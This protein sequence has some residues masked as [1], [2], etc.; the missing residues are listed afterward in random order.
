[1]VT[2]VTRN[3]DQAQWIILKGWLKRSRLELA[4]FD[5]SKQPNSS[6]DLCD[7][8]VERRELSPA[9]ATQA[10]EESIRKGSAPPSLESTIL[11][12]RAVTQRNQEEF[13]KSLDGQYEIV[14]ELSRGAMGVIY[15]AIQRSSGLTVALK[16]MLNRNP[17]NSEIKRFRQ[18]AA[19]L[20]QLKHEHI[21]D[22]L[23]FGI[24]NDQA[25]FA[26]DF[27]EGETLQEAIT[28]TL[29]ES[30]TLPS[31]AFTVQ[32]MID[33]AAALIYCH[34]SQITH[35][36]VKPLN[37]MIDDKTGRAILIDFGL[38]KRPTMI[39]QTQSHGL[40]LSGEM[41][42]TPAF[43]SPEQFAPGS[44]H[45]EIGPHSDIWGFGA[46]LFYALTGVPPY[47]KATLIDIYQ[48]IKHQPTP[49]VRDFNPMLPLWLDTLVQ[50][51]L[52]NDSEA[53][54]SIYEVKDRL[55]EGYQA[56]HSSGSLRLWPI[57][58]SFLL[59]LFV[60]AFVGYSM[61]N[62][63]IVFVSIDELE[64]MTAEDQALFKGQ[65]SRGPT[66]L[67]IN[68]RDLTT[69]QD[70]SFSTSIPLSE[71]LNTIKAEII[72]ESSAVD[73]HISKVFRDS[74]APG[75]VLFNEFK[76]SGGLYILGESEPLTG[77]IF[78]DHPAYV[79]YLDKIYPCDALGRFSL[80]LLAGAIPTEHSFSLHDKAGNVT[81]KV[82]KTLERKHY[83][84]YQ[85][86]LTEER[87]Q[88]ASRRKVEASFGAPTRSSPDQQWREKVFSQFLKSLKLSEAEQNRF[89]PLLTLDDWKRASQGE[90]DSAI[91]M[92]T[93]LLE[94]DF[95]YLETK[96]Y[97]TAPAPHRVAAFEHRETG[98]RLH[99]IPGQT[100]RQTWWPDPT[101]DAQREILLVLA[102]SKSDV[103]YF[104]S[105]ASQLSRDIRAK[106]CRELQIDSQLER[107][108]KGLSR[109]NFD[110][111]AFLKAQERDIAEMLARFKKSPEAFQRL[112][113][114]CKN[115]ND[116][117]PFKSYQTLEYIRP[118]LL[119]QS[120]VSQKTWVQFSMRSAQLPAL[121]KG[122][123]PDLPAYQLSHR[124]VKHWLRHLDLRLP[125]KAEWLYACQASAKTYFYWRDKN[126]QATGHCW[127]QENSGKEVQPVS[128]SPS[129]PNGFGLINMVGN[130]AEWVEPE[131]DLWWSR[132]NLL[133]KTRGAPESPIPW[134][135]LE[136]RVPVLGGSIDWPLFRFQ[137]KPCYYASMNDNDGIWGFRVAASLGK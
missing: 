59:S 101:T 52:E 61:L 97:G 80:P 133:R 36:D 76:E 19:V 86:R 12:Q 112:K 102:D 68:G 126:E 45:G 78:D 9:Q 8:L 95:K 124:E 99:L 123:G 125:A 34:E 26:M 107:F 106:I 94:N 90:Q 10:R 1:M 119:G 51:C 109:Q 77:R 60:G 30:S 108:F 115:H 111:E 14:R 113:L 132:W 74:T 130:V 16:I 134:F 110:T 131:W 69:A 84:P 88:V 85:K 2:P 24:E 121:K 66:A 120:E 21:I 46:T 92:A 117:L 4:L 5:L 11:S 37:I 122:Q 81:K 70:G 137:R 73:T 128:K 55:E 129:G 56:S 75:F 41:V 136:Y 54:P 118:F 29:N 40:T 23:D 114:S 98:L 44:D 63:P 49:S 25:Y 100:R 93:A 103:A 65:L 91:A 87:E 89:R 96:D 67:K 38:L 15:K 62:D 127:I 22:I 39:D 116:W 43:M 82:I 104:Q 42:G 35:R 71:G 18:E 33:I 28:E 17:D 105:V 32:V 7:F 53:R 6:L 79:K 50:D 48:A 83:L 20:I 135:A 64:P 57:A 58:A 27:I 72:I 3:K 13:L 47:N 31:W